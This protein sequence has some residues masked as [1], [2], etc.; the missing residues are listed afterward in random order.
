MREDHC[1]YASKSVRTAKQSSI[2]PAT[3]V[4]YDWRTS[5]TG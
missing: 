5:A 1:G 3:V 2:V 4:E